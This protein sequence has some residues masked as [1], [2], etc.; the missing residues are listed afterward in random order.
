M[1][2]PGS[3]SGTETTSLVPVRR[4]RVKAAIAISRS[5]T[6]TS[7]VSAGCYQVQSNADQTDHELP[8]RIQRVRI[9]RPTIISM[10][11]ILNSAH[12]DA[13]H[14]A[15]DRLRRRKR[16]VDL[17]SV[18]ESERKSQ[19]FVSAEQSPEHK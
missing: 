8:I 10:T 4:P 17:D 5:R 18:A 13:I 2:F 19:L 9:A 7:K 15:L 11:Q 14:E 16:F 12:Q 6:A 3:V 1:S